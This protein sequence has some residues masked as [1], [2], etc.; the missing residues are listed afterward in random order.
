MSFQQ[1]DRAVWLALNAN[2]DN[3]STVH[4]VELFDDEVIYRDWNEPATWKQGYAMDEKGAVTLKGTPKEVTEVRSYKP[5]KMSAAFSED[6]G[7]TDPR[8]V[9]YTGKVFELGSFPDKGFSLSEAEADDAIANFAPAAVDLEHRESVFSGKLGEVRR[10]WREGTRIMGEYFAPRAVRTLLGKDV[11]VSAEWSN[12]PGEPKR[13]LKMALTETPRITDAALTAAFSA[14][15][16]EA[17]N[18]PVMENPQFTQEDRTFFDRLKAFFGVG[19]TPA[20]GTPPVTSSTD[21]DAERYRRENETLKQQLAAQND[22]RLADAAA[23]FADEQV[24]AGKATVAQKD[25]LIA[26]FKALAK[27]DAAVG[28]AMFSDAGV[29]HE[30]EGLKALRAQ[31][32]A[33]EAKPVHDPNA[34][35]TVIQGGQSPKVEVPNQGDIFEARRKAMGGA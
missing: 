31:F 23:K 15:E 29:L 3:E 33:I 4:I 14:A 22:A 16:D 24:A 20:S 30:G 18:E 7:F 11:P 1:R 27:A 17:R 34:Q 9:R 12:R 2:R 28:V 32:A 10:L 13:F 21:P 25:S 8:L 19:G 6:A 35:F 26:Q 5:V